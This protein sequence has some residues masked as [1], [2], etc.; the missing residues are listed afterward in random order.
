MPLAREEVG[1]GRNQGE[2][3][4]VRDCEG[5]LGVADTVCHLSFLCQAEILKK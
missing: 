5:E 2:S 1:I 4:Q 3:R